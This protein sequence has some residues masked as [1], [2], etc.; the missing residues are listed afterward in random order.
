MP[1]NDYLQFCVVDPDGT[2]REIRLKREYIT[3]KTAAEYLNKNVDN[4]RAIQAHRLDGYVRDML[5]DEW[6][7]T[8]SPIIFDEHGNLVDG[9]HRLTGVIKSGKP[10]TF[11]VVRGVSDKAIFAIDKGKPRSVLDSLKIAEDDST[12]CSAKMISL[13]KTAI[14]WGSCGSFGGFVS[15]ADIRRFYGVFYNELNTIIR[16]FPAAREAGICT[17]TQAA[18]FAALLNGVSQ[19]DLAEYLKVYRNWERSYKYNDDAA[20][21]WKKHLVS[22][23]QKGGTLKQDLLYWGF[24]NSL[25]FFITGKKYQV[26]KERLYRYPIKEA[27]EKAIKEEN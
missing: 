6:F 2:A 3:P 19:T 17:A 4:N 14:K 5:H 12:L 1:T 24:Q 25:Y 18:F 7:F 16:I 11:L 9:Q 22:I 10:Q 15:D 13:I 23:T 27:V 26:P 21:K 8:A 20:F